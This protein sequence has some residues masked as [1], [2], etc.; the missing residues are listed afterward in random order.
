[1]RAVKSDRCPGR[2]TLRIGITLTLS[3]RH[4]WLLAGIFIGRLRVPHG[5][6]EKMLLVLG[7]LFNN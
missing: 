5:L 6:A 7:A 3:R 1:M 2:L 4:A